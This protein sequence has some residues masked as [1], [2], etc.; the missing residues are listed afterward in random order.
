MMADRAE[1]IKTRNTFG[2]NCKLVI[3]A[4]IPFIINGNS[5]AVSRIQ[6]NVHKVKKGRHLHVHRVLEL[7]GKPNSQPLTNPPKK[8]KS[9]NLKNIICILFAKI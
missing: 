1:I 5:S 3:V 8:G 7:G 6:Q 4:F 2:S 9:S